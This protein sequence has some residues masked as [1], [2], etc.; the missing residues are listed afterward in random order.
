MNSAPGARWMFL[1]VNQRTLLSVNNRLL[2]ASHDI[3]RR[4]LQ[5]TS[6]SSKK[7]PRSRWYSPD[8]CLWNATW[9]DCPVSRQKYYDFTNN[10]WI[11]ANLPIVSLYS[12]ILIDSI[13]RTCFTFRFFCLYGIFG[14]RWKGLLCSKDRCLPYSGLNVH[15][16]LMLC[17][18]SSLRSS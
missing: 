12:V 1:T 13:F 6:K 8:R 4:V 16:T 3:V 9:V 15:W 11:A 18:L 5:T 2:Q 10:C 7:I 14:L 17:S